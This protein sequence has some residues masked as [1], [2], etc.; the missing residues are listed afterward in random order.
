MTK[1]ALCILPNFQIFNSI[2]YSSLFSKRKGMHELK[3]P[4]PFMLTNIGTNPSK[5]KM[6]N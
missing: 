1:N 3:Y 6:S 4:F 5:N 2:E